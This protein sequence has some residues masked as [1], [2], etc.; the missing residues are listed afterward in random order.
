MYKLWFVL[1]SLPHHETE[2][3]HRRQERTRINKSERLRLRE[4]QGA[5]MRTGCVVDRGITTERDKGVPNAI[6]K[7]LWLVVLRTYLRFVHS[8]ILT[9]SCSVG[10]EGSTIAL[11]SPAIP[12]ATVV[13]AAGMSVFRGPRR[14]VDEGACPPFTIPPEVFGASGS[15]AAASK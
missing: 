5:P 8:K 14:A 11:P 1:S 15:S 2:G 3:G 12:S 10:A 13:L 6:Y 4:Q 7:G 9:F